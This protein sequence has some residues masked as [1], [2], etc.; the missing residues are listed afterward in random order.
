M[1]LRHPTEAAASLQARDGFPLGKGLLLW[2]RHVLDAEAASRGLRRS[3]C[4]WDD[5]LAD[6]RP[7][8]ARVIDQCAIPALEPTD[9]AAARIDAFLSADLKT[10]RSD[11][12]SGAA[13]DAI[14]EWIV[15][16]DQALR[17]LAGNAHA[18]ESLAELDRVTAG[19]DAAL[20]LIGDLAMTLQRDVETLQAALAIEK[21]HV[22]A[23]TELAERRRIELETAIAARDRAEEDVA[24]KNDIIAG[25]QRALQLQS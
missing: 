10:Q 6:W 23:I 4:V 3:V 25:A 2:L 21:G 18:P 17:R 15:A 22:A 14:H 12:D 24:K 9:E 5:L 1:P 13:E 8:L 7:V 20:R 11:A 16:A 19:F